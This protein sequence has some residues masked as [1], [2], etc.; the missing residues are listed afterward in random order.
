MKKHDDD[1]IVDV[2]EYAKSGEKKP[3]CNKFRIKID[4]EKFVVNVPEMTGWQLLELAGKKPI[5]Q[6]S[7][8]QRFKG[9]AT[10]KV[11]YSETTNFQAPGIERFMTLPLDQTEGGNL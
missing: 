6:Y 2:E 11:E 5:E 4:K 10:E 7:I 9:G 1:L 3:K 8:F